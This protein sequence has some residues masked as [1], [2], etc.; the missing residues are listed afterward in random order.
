MELHASP[1]IS[2]CKTRARAVG[3]GATPVGI[4]RYIDKKPR[5]R[6]GL[7]RKGIRAFD[8]Y[9]AFLRELV[10]THSKE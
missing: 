10:D 4:R 6:L 1:C 8:D 7:T 5:T 2:R 9:V 3:F